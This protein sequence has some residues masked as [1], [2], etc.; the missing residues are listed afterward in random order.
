MTQVERRKYLIAALLR[1]Q[2]QYAGLTIPADAQGQKDLLRSL[3]NVR[4]PKP[5]SR[6]LLHIQDEYL[7]YERDK[8]GITDGAKLPSIP[9]DPRLVLW[10]GDITTLK[11]DAIVNAANSGMLGCFQPLHS[12]IDNIIHSRSG[13]QLR[14]YCYDIMN[15]HGHAEPTGHAKI[16]PAFNLPSKYILHTV[17][18]IIYGPVSKQD[19]EALASCYRSCLELAMENGCRSIAFCCISTGE[20][21]F[22]NDM[23][24]EIAVQTVTSFLNSRETDIRVIFNVFKDVDLHMYQKLLGV[25]RC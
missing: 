3:M 14:L 18:P 20:F 23:A 12:C 10:Q 19:C 5:I 9:G 13:I 11:V 21:H 22:P 4:M 8:R 16:T 24:A 2:P 15:K 17:G 1:E 7:Q 25:S 6:D